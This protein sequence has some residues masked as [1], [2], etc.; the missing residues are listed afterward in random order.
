MQFF[1]DNQKELPV[2]GLFHISQLGLDHKTVI[3]DS[4]SHQWQLS[5]LIN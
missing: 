5:F 3:P 4:F 1:D 2:I